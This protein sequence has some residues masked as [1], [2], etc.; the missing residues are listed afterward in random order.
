[1]QDVVFKALADRTRRTILTRLAAGPQ[2]VGALA[3][4][5]DMTRPA[6]AKHLKVLSDGGLVSVTV[7]GR[8]RINTLNPQPLRLVADWLRLFDV[9][10]DVQLAELKHVLEKETRG[11]SD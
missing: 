2:T 9:F 3:S 6:V 8:E 10:W 11:G 7:K 5:F 4:Q 1:M